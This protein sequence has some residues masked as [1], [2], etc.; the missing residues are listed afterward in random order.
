MTTPEL[1]GG[2]GSQNRQNRFATS[3][4]YP[5]HQSSQLRSDLVELILSRRVRE[6]DLRTRAIPHE[7]ERRVDRRT[8]EVG[9]NTEP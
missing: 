6:R 1:L 7:R 2:A 3:S 5:Q 4:R 9:D 8:A